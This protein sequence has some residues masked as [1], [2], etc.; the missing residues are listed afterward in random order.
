MKSRLIREELIGTEAQTENF[1]IILRLKVYVRL[2]T[3]KP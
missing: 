2:C 1:H 3:N